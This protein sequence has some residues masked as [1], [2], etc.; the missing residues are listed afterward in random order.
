MDL[1]LSP[2]RA[3][4]VRHGRAA[5][6]WDDDADPPLDATGREQAAAV[7]DALAALLPEGAPVL[8]SPLR[9]CR[10]TAAVVAERWQQVPQVEPLIA[11]I[12]SPDGVPMGERVAWLRQALTGSWADL[13]PRYA[14]YRD[15]LVARIAG[16]QETSVVVT[17]FVAIN[18]VIAATGD[19]DRLLLRALDNCSI[20]VVAVQADGLELIEVG[21]EADTLI[22]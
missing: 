4:L 1:P 9:R 11:E 10:E 22:R 13:G 20:T 2:V 15:A 17:H 8:T 14:Q 18:A 5:A 3:Y 12:P 7:A 16:L 6:G 19:D 21:H